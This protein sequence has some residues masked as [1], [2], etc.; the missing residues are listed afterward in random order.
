MLNWFGSP[1]IKNAGTLGGNI[2]NGS[3]IGDTM[4]ALY[5]LNAEI[6]L[7]SSAGARR[8]NINDF[9][10]GYKKSVRRTDE[11][12]SRVFIPLPAPSDLFKLYK[13]SKR[14]DLDIST[15][16]GAIW[17]QVKDQ[18]HRRGAHRLRRRR[19]EYPCGC[20]TDR[21]V[22]RSASPSRR[23]DISHG[24]QARPHRDHADLGRPRRGGVSVAAGRK[25]VA[26]V[27]S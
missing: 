5:V 10:T 12:L 9:Y 13:I 23:G 24:G 27:F 19:A 1:L 21:S 14:K 16:T 8:V 6:E 11:L 22:A 20:E 15:L 7:T 2:A 18:I 26:E 25:F 3:P 4:P 17:M